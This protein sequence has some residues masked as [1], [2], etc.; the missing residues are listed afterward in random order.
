[1]GYQKRLYIQREG[2]VAREGGR[3]RKG[4]GKREVCKEGR[5][6]ETEKGGRK[7]TGE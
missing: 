2:E 1:M 4:E 7:D 6:R 3:K 5:E